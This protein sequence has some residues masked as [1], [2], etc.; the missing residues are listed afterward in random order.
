MCV[1][2]KSK[3]HPSAVRTSEGAGSMVLYKVPAFYQPFL[4]VLS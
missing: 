4:A 1:D 2:M 3:A